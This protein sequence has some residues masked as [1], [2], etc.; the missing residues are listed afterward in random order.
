MVKREKSNVS[1]VKVSYALPPLSMTA[2][3]G[4]IFDL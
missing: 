1:S 3:V 4:L 2:H